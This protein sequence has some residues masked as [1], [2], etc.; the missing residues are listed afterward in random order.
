MLCNAIQIQACKL[1]YTMQYKYKHVNY[2]M[3]CNTIQACKLCYVIQCNIRMWTM[4]C[5]AIQ[6]KHVN[7]VM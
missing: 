6:Y 3:Y 2:V 4:L 7:Y 1:C 5:I